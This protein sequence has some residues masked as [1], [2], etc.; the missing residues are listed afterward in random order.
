MNLL[1][2]KSLQLLSENA[3]KASS[4]M[5]L[6]ILWGVFFLSAHLQAQTHE[7]LFALIA[8]DTLSNLCG[9]IKRDMTNFRV[10]LNDVSRYT[11][12]QVKVVELS[13]S[14]LTA[15]GIQGWLADVKKSQPEIV[16]IYYSGHGYRTLT[17]SPSW[18]LLYFSSKGESLDSQTLWNG[19]NE[20]KARL[21]IVVL[22]CCNRPSLQASLCFQGMI[23]GVGWD[24]KNHPG[25]KTLFLKTQGSVIAA[26]AS[27]GEAAFAFDN[28]SLFTNSLTQTIRSSTGSKDV[29]WDAIFTRTSTLCAHMQRPI[30]LIQTTSWLPKGK[31]TVHHTTRRGK[32]KSAS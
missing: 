14:D 9:P 30:C 24:N 13:G 17:T 28:G 20:A 2:E 12:V 8:G 1:F 29:S 32:S 6:A 18:P 7:T 16:L 4:K 23:K 11:G 3:I 31:K 27:P 10:L 26:G 5:F 21:V 25:F 22:D 15:D 19:L